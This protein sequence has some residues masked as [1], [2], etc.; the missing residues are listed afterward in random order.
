MNIIGT[1]AQIT[2]AATGADAVV[3]DFAK[4]AGAASAGAASV[5]AST[6]KMNAGVASFAKLGAAVAAVGIGIGLVSIDIA[7]KWETTMQTVQG[8]THVTTAELDFMSQQVMRLGREYPKSLSDIAS[9]YEHAAN[10]GYHYQDANALVLAGMKDAVA[11]GA[12]V[13]D[14]VNTLGTIMK[15]LHDPV[16][17]A[18]RDI[19]I[20]SQAAAEGNIRLPEMVNNFNKVGEVGGS[21]HQSLTEVAAGYS[22]LTKATGDAGVAQTQWVNILMHILDPTAKAKTL[23]AELSQTTGVDLVKAQQEAASGQMSLS[24]YMDLTREATHGNAAELFTLFGGLRGGAGAVA[25]LGAHWADYGKTLADLNS[26]QIQTGSIMDD[27]S[28]KMGSQLTSQVKVL[29]NDVQEA[30]IAF[31]TIFVPAVQQVIE[32]LA[33][34]AGGATDFARAHKTLVGDIGSGAAVLLGLGVGIWAIEKALKAVEAATVAVRAIMGAGWILDVARGMLG[35]EAATAATAVGEVAVGTQ[36]AAASVEVAGLGTMVERTSGLL[37]PYQANLSAAAVEETAVG[38]A[39][40]TAAISVGALAVGL[41]LV[42]AAIGGVVIGWKQHEAAMSSNKMQIGELD[43]AIARGDT[44]LT[45]Y[46]DAIVA[47]GPASAGMASGLQ[48][49]IEKADDHREA[50]KKQAD[51]A[52][53]TTMRFGDL[54]IGLK[55]TGDAAQTM[56]KSIDPSSVAALDKLAKAATDSRDKLAAALYSGD[57]AALPAL[58]KAAIKDAE[59]AQK[60]ADARTAADKLVAGSSTNSTAEILS[61]L[62]RLE[63]EGWARQVDN[64]TAM[65]T[66]VIDRVKTMRD[67]VVAS[68]HDVTEALDVMSA[69]MAVPASLPALTMPGGSAMGAA[70][71]GV[72]VAGS[73]ASSGPGMASALFP[74]EAIAAM[75]A[76]K[77]AVAALPPNLQGAMSTFTDEFVAKVTALHNTEVEKLAAE[78]A[79]DQAKRV[80]INSKLASD[81]TKL[82]EAANAKRQAADSAYYSKIQSI[83][84]AHNARLEQILTTF[85]ANFQLALTTYSGAVAALQTKAQQDMTDHNDKMAAILAKANAELAAVHGKNQQQQRANIEA[86]AANAD[87]AETKR[88]AGTEAN[89]NHQLSGLGVVLTNHVTGYQN[90]VKTQTAAADATWHKGLQGAADVLLKANTATQTTLTT[91]VQATRD[92]AQVALDKETAMH[93]KNVAAIQKVFGDAVA[94]LTTGM[95]AMTTGAGLFDAV[96]KAADDLANTSLKAFAMALLENTQSLANFGNGV[97]E[98]GSAQ[99]HEWAASRQSLADL[100]DKSIQAA[101]AS[102]EVADAMTRATLI[103]AK[104]SGDWSVVLAAGAKAATDGMKN[105]LDGLTLAFMGGKQNV[106]VLIASYQKYQAQQDRQT[107]ATIQAELALGQFSAALSAITSKVNADVTN[108]LDA[109]VLRILHKTSPDLT[110]MRPADTSASTADLVAS[111][112]AA[113]KAQD[114]LTQAQIMADL[115][116]GQFSAALSL[117]TSQLTSDVSNAF[118]SIVISIQKGIPVTQDQI[119]AYNKAKAAIDQNTADTIKAD[120][121]TGQFSA[122]LSAISGQITGNVNNAFDSIVVSIQKGIPVTQAQIASYAAAKVAQDQL[123]A[124]TIQANLKIGNYAAAQSATA[125]ILSNNVNNALAK[126]AYDLQNHTGDLNADRQAIINASAAQKQNTDALK[127]GSDLLLTAGQQFS[128]GLSAATAQQKESTGALSLYFYDLANNIAYTGPPLSTLVD[129]VNSANAATAQYTQA[130]IQAAYAAGNVFDA[131][132]MQAKATYDAALAAYENAKAAGVSGAALDTLFQ[133]AVTAGTALAAFSDA[134]KEV[135]DAINK[136]IAALDPA[137][138]ALGGV[139]ACGK[140]AATSLCAS[141]NAS[142]AGGYGVSLSVGAGSGNPQVPG[143]PSISVP[144]TTSGVPGGYKPTTDPSTSAPVNQINPYWVGNYSMPGYTVITGGGGVQDYAPGQQLPAAYKSFQGADQVPA[145]MWQTTPMTW[146]G[147]SMTPTPPS[148]YGIMNQYG[149]FY[150]SPN[151]FPLGDIYNASR[152][153]TVGINVGPPGQPYLDQFGNPI[154]PAPAGYMPPNVPYGGS[155]QAGAGGPFPYPGYSTAGGGQ[156]GTATPSMNAGSLGGGLGG[157]LP[158]TGPPSSTG[159]VI[160]TSSTDPALAILQQLLA[161]AQKQ[162]LAD[163]TALKD[164]QYATTL[165]ALMATISKM[166]RSGRGQTVGGFLPWLNAGGDLAAL[167]NP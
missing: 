127:Q 43:A 142:A 5:E 135:T 132:Q 95:A 164:Q 99:R 118:D 94:K 136:N 119:A 124:S 55:S 24:H 41:G 152:A 63:S 47:L 88:Y 129:N 145:N 108:A 33:K 126:Y 2:F 6:A 160:G 154:G 90:T 20:L 149:G 165:L 70:P 79:R 71:H 30:A 130:Q 73:Q 27:L 113:K 49:V 44:G 155:G 13:G 59:A 17:M 25:L 72:N 21:M 54:S 23:I 106:E 114:D 57:T 153:A 19:A 1:V 159:G 48:K 96:K 31:G 11:T 86:W 167:Q 65:S 14:T 37:V 133:A 103:V 4:V 56:A 123:T 107:A 66:A 117:I 112:A 82:Y 157:T 80:E 116:T 7:S 102:K 104:A 144:S 85:T 147:T 87:A 40:D 81:L 64:V 46:R 121:A 35:L 138:K 67:S 39:A 148:G 131:Q 32:P 12:K 77:D 146:S 38:A 134:T 109:L 125:S 58:T 3:G 166:A 150:T 69:A 101:W 22:V 60:W 98:T 34:A 105:A 151:M 83:N 26:K 45:G 115:A 36:A 15:N 143:M 92:A 76:F 9:A 62:K 51:Q 10:L 156:Y 89:I 100:R 111:Y 50:M 122:A 163:E 52:V 16:S 74:P 120:L 75:A 42:T 140:G 61:N 137:T 91:H 8:N 18:G 162:L 93:E 84:D 78:N 68:L 128:Q 28:K 29:G 158:S 141:S 53:A 110:G 161:V 97:T 139:A